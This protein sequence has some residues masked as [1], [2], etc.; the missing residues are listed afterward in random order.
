M[1]NL[2]RE[3]LQVAEEQGWSLLTLISVICS[4]VK[5]H[6]LETELVEWCENTAK[7]E[8]EECANE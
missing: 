3:V 5:E 1:D 6:E 8:D 2:H 4:F 7:E